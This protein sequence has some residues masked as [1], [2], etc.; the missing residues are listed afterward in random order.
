MNKLNLLVFILLGNLLFSCATTRSGIDLI[1]NSEVKP[2][3]YEIGRSCLDEE[4]QESEVPLDGTIYFRVM[5]WN[6]GTITLD[7]FEYKT[8][9]E[10]SNFFID[11]IEK[12]LE[13]IR[14]KRIVKT[15]EIII[16]IKVGTALR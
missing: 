5:T 15:K 6:S 8:N 10:P 9:R 16:N 14:V 2:T 7:K 3:V 12:E 11:C 1:D 4:V 13:S